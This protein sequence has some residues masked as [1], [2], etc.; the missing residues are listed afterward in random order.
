MSDNG[1]VQLWPTRLLQR[2]LPGAEQANAVL[3][4]LILEQESRHATG[5]MTSDYQNQDFF[6]Y[7]HPAVEW[8][9]A[10]INKTVG[11]YLAD[12]SIGYSV[13]WSLQGWVNINRRG[14]YHNLHNH[15]HS[16]LSGTYYIAMPSEPGQDGQRQDL[17]PGAISFFDP[18]GQ[19]NMT[20][21]AG[22]AQIDPEYRVL[23]KAGTILLWPSFLHHCVHPNLSDELRVSM[24]FN[25]L[26]K[27]QD[28]YVPRH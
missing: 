17:N 25:V 15:P 20:A 12:Q 23:P 11:D 18:R 10:C 19:A 26:L 5:S 21:I 27:W 7:E 22:D 6:S 13:N 8:L 14:D 3:Q 28:D 1:I 2:E 16:Y 9:K 4:A 24:S